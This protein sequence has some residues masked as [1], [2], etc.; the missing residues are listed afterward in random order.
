MT[1]DCGLNQTKIADFMSGFIMGFTG[2]DHKAYFETCMIDT[3]QFEADM[4]TAVNDFATKDNQQVIQGV[5][6]VLSD[7]PELNGFLAGCPDAAADI[8]VTADWFKYWKSQGEMKVYSTAYKN[9]VG[10]MET[11]KTDVDALSTDYDAGDYFGTANMAASIA[12]IAL[13][14]PASEFLQ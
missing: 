1:I 7:M 3:P 8:A 10:Q 12:K 14:V 2:N 9:V 4:C 11:I 6:L 13:P 5:Q